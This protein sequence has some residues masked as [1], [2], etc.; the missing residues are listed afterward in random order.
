M[1]LSF[2][3]STSKSTHPFVIYRMHTHDQLKKSHSNDICAGS[4]FIGAILAMQ[5]SAGVL[6]GLHA[7]FYIYD[8]V[9]SSFICTLIKQIRIHMRAHH[10]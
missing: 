8:T 5:F 7:L 10:R 1:I 9:I 6:H 3:I 4:Q 2:V